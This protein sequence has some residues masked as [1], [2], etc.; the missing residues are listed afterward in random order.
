MFC[1]KLSNV[2]DQIKKKQNKHGYK[3]A[4]VRSVVIAIPREDFCLIELK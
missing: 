2:K 3:Y 1:Q 4:C